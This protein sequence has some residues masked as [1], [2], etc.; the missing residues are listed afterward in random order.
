MTEDTSESLLELQKLD[1]EIAEARGVLEEFEARL[2]VVAEPYEKLDKEAEGLRKRLKELTLDERRVESAAAEKRVRLGKLE[3]RMTQV[4]NLRE[5]AAV[6]AEQDLVRR[7]VEADEQEALSLLDLIRRS[8]EKLEGVSAALEEAQVALEPQRQEI[9]S[10]QSGANA[11]F[12]ELEK[13]RGVFASQ[14]SADEL[15]IYDHIRSGSR[16]VAVSPM[17]PDGA[18]GHC[19]TMVPLQVQNELRAGRRRVRCEGCG[20]ILAAPLSEEDL[21]AE[22]AAATARATEKAEAEAEAEE[23]EAEGAVA[24]AEEADTVRIP[25]LAPEGGA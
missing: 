22:A 2:E 25:S 10:E 7:A 21:E 23:N 16:E 19:H 3:E 9:L 1:L 12:A 6:H 18:C 5:E 4:R 20:V 13:R 14:V 15:R 24:E 11:T 17:T 8:D